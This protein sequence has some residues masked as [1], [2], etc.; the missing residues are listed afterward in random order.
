[1]AAIRT[2]YISYMVEEGVREEN[3]GSHVA[4]NH[5][6]HNSHEADGRGCDCEQLDVFWFSDV[7]I[8]KER[9]AVPGREELMPQF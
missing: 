8:V 5:L 4:G 7:V 6:P 1:M 9:D 3:S 2:G